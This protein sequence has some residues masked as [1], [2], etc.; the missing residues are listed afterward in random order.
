MY[1]IGKS[2]IGRMRVDLL[3]AFPV[4][5]GFVVVLSFIF[6]VSLLFTLTHGIV[7]CCF[8]GKIYFIVA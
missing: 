5:L 7:L 6:E 3:I 4:C 1:E 2:V 8:K